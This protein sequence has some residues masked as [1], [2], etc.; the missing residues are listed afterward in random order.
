[1]KINLEKMRYRVP[2]KCNRFFAVHLR[3]IGVCF[4][5]A[6]MA[7][8]VALSIFTI[9]YSNSVRTKPIIVIM[10]EVEDPKSVM[11]R[12]RRLEVII[13][14]HFAKYDEEFRA[15]EGA[16]QKYNF[17]HLGDWVEDIYNKDWESPT[18]AVVCLDMTTDFIY[19]YFDLQDSGIIPEYNEN[20][21]VVLTLE[22]INK[23]L[24]RL[25]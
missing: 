4:L 20:D 14:I 24:R 6:L 16:E 21:K 22:Q 23:L 15:E 3:F 9:R 10:C 12:C 13:D 5:V 7:I 1:M 25:L 18:T 19:S 17:S 8:T 11:E 2:N